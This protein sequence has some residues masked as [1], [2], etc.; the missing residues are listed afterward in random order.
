MPDALWLYG[1]LSLSAP[2]PVGLGGA[3]ADKS[4]NV[5]SKAMHR[6]TGVPVPRRPSQGRASSS[7]C[8]ALWLPRQLERRSVATAGD[9]SGQGGRRARFYRRAA[10]GQPPI[11]VF[12]PCERI[13][14]EAREE[15]SRM[16]KLGQE[17]T[18]WTQKSRKYWFLMLII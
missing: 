16:E 3:A 14:G 9:I 1:A 6:G 18:L 4:Q 8:C 7:I 12:P 11:A 5:S 10:L 2:S 17:T 15:A 13:E